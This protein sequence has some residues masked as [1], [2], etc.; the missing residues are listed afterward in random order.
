MEINSERRDAI[1]K[2]RNEGKSYGEICKALNCDKSLV[3]FYCGKRF[4]PQAQKEKENS[5]LEYEQIVCDAVS[6]ATSINDACKLL[7]KRGTTTNYSFIKK[8]IAKYNLDT[9]HFS[10]SHA[11]KKNSNFKKYS[12]EE[13]YC[14]NS[15]MQNTN[16]LRKRLFRDGLKE[17]KCEC[18]GNSEWM[19]KEIPLQVHHIN[20]NNRDNR[21]ENLQ[22]LCPNC[23][24]F[25]DTY[26]GKSKNKKPK[27]ER[28]DNAPEKDELI[29]A[30]KEFGNFVKVGE[31]FGVSDNAIRKW[32]KKRG[33]PHT[34]KELS[35]F[36]TN[37]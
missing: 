35:V 15:L 24:A 11:P 6:K 16:S 18:C 19:G 10:D 31:F 12:F 28:A 9:S 1:L 8:I 25:T 3:A 21:L 33:I 20:G 22:I 26:C 32:C 14:E 2:L 29:K 23:H 30:F 37:L 13:V 36:L 27:K 17:P 4:D 34:A 7:G 5:R